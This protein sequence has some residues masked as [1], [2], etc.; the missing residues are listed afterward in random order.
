MSTV[1]PALKKD[2]DLLTGP[3]IKSIVKFFLPIA[4]G[5]LFQQLYNAVDAFVVSKYVGTNALAAVG[6]S[7]AVLSN[8]IIGFFVALT[9]GCAVVIA[10]LFGSG[11]YD[12]IRSAVKTS[13]FFSL[14]LGLV[15]GGIVIALSPQL[16]RLLKTPDDTF[17]DALLY[18]RIYFIGTVFLLVYNM[19]AGILRA[20]GNARFPFICLFV[21]CIAN[22]S[23]DFLFVLGFNMG[24]RGVAIA[25][26]ISEAITA[27]MVTVKLLATKSS[28]KL[29]LRKVKFNFSILK[30]MLGIG[31]PTG[32]QCSMY[33][34]SNLILQIGVNSLG[35]L[36]VASWAMSGKVDGIFWAITSAFGT[37][38][39]NFV[40]QNYGA[41]Q[42]GRIKQCAKRGLIFHLI[43]T[44]VISGLLLGLGK[45]VLALLTDDQGVISTTYQIM[46]YF[47][48]F[49]VTW[50]FIEVL[51]AVLRGIGDTL[52]PSVIQAVGICVFRIIWVYT[53]FR[54]YHTLFVLS[55]SYMSSWV[56]TDIAIIIYYSLKSKKSLTSPKDSVIEH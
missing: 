55:M 26:V 42:F 39:T 36:V 1:S 11:E 25:T 6:G 40:G 33:G 3:V 19:G 14:L 10:Q 4:A 23:L 9:G 37:A 30:S 13:Y 31:V 38:V 20:V 12:K 45:F 51:P 27:I 53:I 7:P 34:I 24:V 17:Q 49:Y 18:Q 28:C 5:T 48:P 2:N 35:T 47:V 56:I 32:I 43:M 44:A 29:L 46:I 8:L 41:K 54:V 22:I 50:S 52:I 15:V 16:L 21:G